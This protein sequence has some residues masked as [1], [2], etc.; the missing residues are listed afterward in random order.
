MAR[1]HGIRDE[2]SSRGS[3]D[4]TPVFRAHGPY[5]AQTWRMAGDSFETVRTDS[6]PSS[7]DSRSGSVL[8]MRFS[9]SGNEIA[10]KF[11]NDG[12]SIGI[13]QLQE[14]KFVSES[15]CSST[16]IREFV[17]LPDGRRIAFLDG[18]GVG[19]LNVESHEVEFRPTPRQLGLTLTCVGD[20]IAVG[21]TN[22]VSV[23]D[24]NLALQSTLVWNTDPREQL[25]IVTSDGNHEFLRESTELAYVVLHDNVQETLSREEM[26]KRYGWKNDSSKARLF[27]SGVGSQVP[28]PGEPV[29]P[30]ALVQSPEPIDGVDSWT[31]EPVDHRSRAVL[32]E[33]SPSGTLVATSGTDGAYVSGMPTAGSCKS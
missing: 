23:Y 19:V 21:T 1:F 17:W 16:R 31:L 18:E 3:D 33:Y 6:I 29:S 8:G 2:T 27:A 14:A 30:L 25:L 28:V 9:P 32:A 13:W 26:E 12:K 5:T 15:E 22:Q 20:T 10:A 11:S 7:G 4:R 24:L